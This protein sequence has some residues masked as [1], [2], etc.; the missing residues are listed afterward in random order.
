MSID[1]GLRYPHVLAGIVGVSGFVHNPDILVNELSPVALQQRL[2]VTHGYMDPLVPFAVVRDQIQT[3]KAAGLQIEWRE[4]VKAHN[5]AGESEL[6]VI[7]SFIRER[8]GE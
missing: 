5:I 2:L 4:F 7:R 1:V 8:Y 6:Q 3:L